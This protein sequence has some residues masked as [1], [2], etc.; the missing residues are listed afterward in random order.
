M[1]LKRNNIPETL[2]NMLKVFHELSRHYEQMMFLHANLNM[3]KENVPEKANN[4]FIELRFNYD[5]K[6]EITICHAIE[7]DFKDDQEIMNK[8]ISEISSARTADLFLEH[9]ERIKS[10]ELKIYDT[11]YKEIVLMQYK[12]SD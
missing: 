8:G 5:S 11:D 12:I 4:E 7:I 2:T 10:L 1:Q 9:F 3:V 6:K